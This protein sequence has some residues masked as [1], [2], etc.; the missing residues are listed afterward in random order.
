[1]S[2]KTKRA[3]FPNP[4]LHIIGANAVGIALNVVRSMTVLLGLFCSLLHRFS[5]SEIK[6][7]T[8]NKNA[9]KKQNGVKKISGL[10][11]L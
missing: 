7:K 4:Q 3:C 9:S 11:G 10:D 5:V 6:S 2:L 1:M 8:E